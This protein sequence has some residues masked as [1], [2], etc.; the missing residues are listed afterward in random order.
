MKKLVLI[1]VF[2][3]IAAT[4]LSACDDLVNVPNTVNENIQDTQDEA[5]EDIQGSIIVEND[6][7]VDM[8]ILALG[9][10]NI[11]LS[12][13][14][15][16]DNIIGVLGKQKR[17]TYLQRYSENW[18]YINYNGSNAFITAN[19]KYT[20]IVDDFQ[21]NDAIENII[22]EGMAQLGVPYEFGSK[23]LLRLDGTLDPYFTGTTFDCSAFV[24][25]AFYMGAEI[26]LKGDSRNQ[27]LEGEMIE[28]ENL[29]RG[30][31]IF[32]TTPA[33]QYNTGVSRIGHVVIYLGDNQ[34]L[35]THGAGGV[36]VDSL[37]GVWDQRYEFARRML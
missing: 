28:R 8:S 9:N 20:K 23:R 26:V 16:E 3:L 36:K 24:Q 27:S 19:E 33:R 32:M 25:Y 7:E 10:V 13:T 12:P 17:V 2:V 34:I 35:H 22:A 15:T 18:Y 31:L 29:Q 4:L 21:T 6:F 1:I 30:D 14:T 37:T 5:S 11:R